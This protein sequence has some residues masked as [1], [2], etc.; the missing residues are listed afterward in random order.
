V[1]RCVN[2]I[3]HLEAVTHAENTRRSPTPQ[4]T[5]CKHGHPL[6][7]ENLHVQSNGE[8]ECLACRRL[9]SEA[10]RR[11][12]GVRKRGTFSLLTEQCRR[13]HPWSEDNIYWEFDPRVQRAH[14]RCKTCKREREAQRMRIRS[15]PRA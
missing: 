2:F 7:G 12:Q 6:S 14:R 13:G 10:K 15:R 8:R 4:K 5:H 1:R 11:R 9:R 3:E